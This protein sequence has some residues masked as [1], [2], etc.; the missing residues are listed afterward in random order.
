MEKRK[1]QNSKHRIMIFVLN[2]KR[3]HALVS[4]RGGGYAPT[5][6]DPRQGKR[7]KE[8]RK[9]WR[10]VFIVYSMSFLLLNDGLGSGVPM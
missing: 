9:G 3:I 5:L 4:A 10:T 6:S 1:L 8:Q 2:Y 7:G